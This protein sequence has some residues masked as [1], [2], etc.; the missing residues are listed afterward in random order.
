MFDNYR[1]GD[2]FDY[3]RVWFLSLRVNILL[4]IGL[5]YKKFWLIL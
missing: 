1:V 3:V 5:L 2:I 4:G